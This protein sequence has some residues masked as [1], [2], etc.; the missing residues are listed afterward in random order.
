MLAG[1]DV[2]AERHSS[3]TKTVEDNH[4]QRNPR[5]FLEGVGC[6]QTCMEPGQ[7]RTDLSQ[8]RSPPGGYLTAKTAITAKTNNAGSPMRARRRDVKPKYQTRNIADG[9][10]R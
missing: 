4:G 6:R 3:V 5:Q 8:T 2:A 1:T 10:R 7:C 9:G